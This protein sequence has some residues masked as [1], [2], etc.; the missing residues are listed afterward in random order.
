MGL[1][2]F[3][4]LQ[5]VMPE[6]SPSEV[7]GFRTCVATDR[8]DSCSMC[9]GFQPSWATGHPP[10]AG[11]CYLILVF[12]SNLCDTVSGTGSV[13]PFMEVLMKI[14]TWY[15]DFLGLIK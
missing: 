7:F 13:R 9:A 12:P 14:N 5:A 10:S 8:S 1:K 6:K 4:P 3:G 15:L 11:K 2:W